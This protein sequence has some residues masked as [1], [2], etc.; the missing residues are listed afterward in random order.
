[1]TTQTTYS[2]EDL[3]NA[4]MQLILLNNDKADKL[5]RV[6]HSGGTKF[7]SLKDFM[8]KIEEWSND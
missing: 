7:T 2:N 6:S 8:D 3:Q 1:M 4:V 5:E